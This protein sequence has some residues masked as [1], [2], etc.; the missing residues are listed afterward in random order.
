M[1][2]G[3]GTVDVSQ[4]EAEETSIVEGPQNILFLSVS[5]NKSRNILFPSVSATSS[6]QGR[7]NSK[8]TRSE[9]V[10]KK[11]LLPIIG[12]QFFLGPTLAP[13][14]REFEGLETH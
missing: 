1:F 5:V 14:R 6:N 2:C 12:M 13:N 4:D 9:I 3:P 11:A 8:R 7:Q 10:F